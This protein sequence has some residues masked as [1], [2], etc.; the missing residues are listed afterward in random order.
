MNSAAVI[1]LAGRL[2]WGTLILGG[3]GLLIDQ[4][5]SWSVDRCGR[6]SSPVS[7]D[8]QWKEVNHD[9]GDDHDI[10][11]TADNRSGGEPVAGLD[12]V[13]PPDAGYRG[14]SGSDPDREIR[15]VE[16]RGLP[17]VD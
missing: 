8:P 2:C 16:K 15:A 4:V 6:D 14:D 10:A 1:E 9:S 13:W 7:Q 11:V 5:M 17:N 3:I 12:P